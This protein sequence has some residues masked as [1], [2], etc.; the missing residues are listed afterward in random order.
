[1]YAENIRYFLKIDFWF[2]KVIG[3]VRIILDSSNEV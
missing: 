3:L 2:Q 1:M